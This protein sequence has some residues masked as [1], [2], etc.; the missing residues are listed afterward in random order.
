MRSQ[1]ERVNERMAALMELS[2]QARGVE[3]TQEL[4]YLVVNATH[5]LAPYRQAILWRDVHK[6]VAL[7]GLVAPDPNAPMIRWLGELHRGCLAERPAGPV[8]I[9]AL[10]AADQA[11]WQEYLPPFALWL[12]DDGPEAAELG[13]LLVREMAWTEAE[14]AL[15]QEWWQVWAHAH[16]ALH[17][18]K[19]ARPKLSLERV[20]TWLLPANRPWWRKRLTW[21]AAA[22]LALMLFPVRMTVIAPGQLVPVDPLWV[23]S[24]IEGVVAEVLVSPTDAVEAGDALFRF[25]NKVLESRVDV[26]RQAFSTATAQYQQLSQRALSDD[27]SGADLIQAAGAMEQKRAELRF[28][29]SRLSDA[30]VRA[31]QGGVAI[32]DSAS[33]WVGQPVSV[34]ERIMRIVDPTK[35]EIEAWL[36][37]ADAVGLDAGSS[38][39]LYLRST[40]LNPVS[41]T[42]RYVAY[43]A[44]ERPSGNVAYRVRARID[45]GSSYRIGLKGTTRLSGGWTVLGYWILRRPIATLR[46]RLGV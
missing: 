33:A 40:P 26:A 38:V 28:L 13:L 30:T 1:A 6:P 9:E 36:P 32:F 22:L 16:R 41:G 45:D 14:S 18:G 34:G 2:R 15:I 44:T 42:V 43:D 7:S 23:R 19:R 31:Q 5:R 39:N 46:T 37:V 10:S 8:D 29:E 12:P 11:A 17:G 4:D 25:D 27:E 21:I 24:P 20:R 3:Q 35:S